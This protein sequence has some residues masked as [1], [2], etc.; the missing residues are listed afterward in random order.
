V[1]PEHVRAFVEE[2]RRA[3]VRRL[4]YAELPGA[5][6][7]FDLFHS[8]RFDTVINGIDAFATAIAAR[9]APTAREDETVGRRRADGQEMVAPRRSTG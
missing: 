7:S 9:A 4:G 1:P 6:H 8:I 5:Q 3:G 2:L